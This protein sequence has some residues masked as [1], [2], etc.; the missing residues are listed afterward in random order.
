MSP[1]LLEARG[2]MKM[3]A[4]LTSKG[5]GGRLVCSTCNL[6]EGPGL[7][8]VCALLFIPCWEVWGCGTGGRTWALLH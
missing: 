7:W 8:D 2:L 4:L 1:E 3:A 6:R 5:N